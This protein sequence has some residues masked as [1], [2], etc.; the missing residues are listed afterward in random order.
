MLA[1]VGAPTGCSGHRA[2]CRVW[3]EQVGTAPG[4]PRRLGGEEIGERALGTWHEA[5]CRGA[6]EN[7]EK[8]EAK[9]GVTGELECYLLA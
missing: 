6:G 9:G 1:G 8:V 2:G 7:G 3:E 5:G 4:G